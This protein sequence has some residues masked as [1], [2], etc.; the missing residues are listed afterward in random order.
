MRTGP[1]WRLLPSTRMYLSNHN[2]HTKACLNNQR[3][4]VIHLNIKPANFHNRISQVHHNLP[5]QRTIFPGHSPLAASHHHPSNNNH[6]RHLSDPW[7][8]IPFYH[9]PHLQH[10]INPHTHHYHSR[11]STQLTRP[12][13]NMRIIPPPLISTRIYLPRLLRPLL[14]PLPSNLPHSQLLL[15]HPSN[16]SSIREACRWEATIPLTRTLQPT[17]QRTGNSGGIRGMYILRFIDLW[18]GKGVRIRRV[19]RR[20]G[21]RRWRGVLISF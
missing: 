16:N 1:G 12:V 14:I 4:S 3:T 8:K 17:P 9:N 6:E 7:H 5:L 15:L 19:G 13:L 11:L 18:K 20:E 2:T 10:P 21:W